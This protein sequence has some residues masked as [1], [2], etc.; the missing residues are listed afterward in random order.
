MMVFALIDRIF[1]KV[2]KERVSRYTS[3]A[4]EL[5]NVISCCQNEYMTNILPSMFQDLESCQKALD[6]Y[7]EAKRNKFPRF[8]FVSNPALLL[9]LSQGSDQNA[10]QQ[11]FAKVSVQQISVVFACVNQCYMLSP[12]DSFHDLRSVNTRTFSPSKIQ[13]NC[14]GSRK[15]FQ[16][17]QPLAV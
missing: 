3:K 4:K 12:L 17:S 16:E 9:V 8:Y 13:L 7:L 6:G 11:C 1:L 15:N 14:A 2:D 10:V 5:K